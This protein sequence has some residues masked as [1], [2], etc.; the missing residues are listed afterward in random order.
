MAGITTTSI[1]PAPVQQSFNMK[2]LS[3]KVPN[4]IHNIPADEYR[5]PAKGGTT[6]RMRRF[7]KIG[8]ALVPLGNSGVTPPAKNL[9]AIDIDAKMSFYGTYIII[10]EQVELQ[11][12]NPVLNEAANLLGLSLRETE[13]TLTRDMLASTSSFI[14]CTGGVNGDNPTELTRSDINEMVRTLVGNDAW[15]VFRKIGG[16]DK[17]GTSPIRD[18][19]FALCHSDLI[20]QFDNINGFVEKSEYSHPEKTMESEWG[21]IGNLRFLVSSIGSIT[22][23]ASALGNDVYNIFCVGL[24]AYGVVKQDEYNAQFIYRP[25]IYSDP[26]AQN[27][28]VGWKT[29]MVPRITNDQWVG[30]LRCTLV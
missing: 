7:N 28:S 19:F 2:L 8:T 14:N 13:D 21:S 27:A 26:L 6:I 22:P 12:Q 9:T 29:A 20:S 10:N 4:F 5:M 30:N 16:E 1:L 11:S 23:N 3:V 24:E 15:T 17:F 25:P 18:S